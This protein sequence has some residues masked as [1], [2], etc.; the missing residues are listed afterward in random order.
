MRAST[1]T[2]RE[3]ETKRIRHVDVNPCICFALDQ[4]VVTSEAGKQ[5]A[6]TSCSASRPETPARIG[7]TTVAQSVRAQT[8][9]L[10]LHGADSVIL[11]LISHR[12]L[13]WP[14]SKQHTRLELANTNITPAEDKHGSGPPERAQNSLT[15]KQARRARNFSLSE[16]TSRPPPHCNYASCASLG[17]TGRVRATGFTTA[18]TRMIL[19]WRPI[20][21][22]RFEEL[23]ST[24]SGVARKWEQS[25]KWRPRQDGYT[26]SWIR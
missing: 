26:R 12:C 7:R 6:T 3:R 20:G 24:R 16:Q 11:E 15:D 10:I 2:P 4:R 25:E 5:S 8:V 21:E 23:R 9:S 14:Y 1:R 22:A 18:T 13:S 19:P 17:P